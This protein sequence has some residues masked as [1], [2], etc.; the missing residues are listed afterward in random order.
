MQQQDAIS[1]KSPVIAKSILIP[2]IIRQVLHILL[3]VLRAQAI[4]FHSLGAFHGLINRHK[5]D[6]NL[7]FLLHLCYV[8]AQFFLFS[9]G[10]YIRIIVDSFRRRICIGPGNLIPRP[11]Y[12]CHHN[13][14]YNQ[15]ANSRKP[16]TKIAQ[17]LFSCFFSEIIFHIHNH[18]FLSSGISLP[19]ANHSAYLK[20]VLFKATFHASGCSALHG[21]ESNCV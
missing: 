2:E 10:Q 21:K 6:I 14:K 11:F 7:I 13:T 19:A 8:A 20:A 12:Q 5:H 18:F 15:Y 17:I 3:P 1:L 9:I 16:K 4:L